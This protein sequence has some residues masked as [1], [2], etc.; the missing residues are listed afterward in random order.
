LGHADRPECAPAYLRDLVDRI[1]AIDPYHPVMLT[2]FNPDVFQMYAAIPDVYSTNNFPVSWHPVSIV[3]DWL[4]SARLSMRTGEPLWSCLQ[5]FGGSSDHPAMPTPA[6]I[7]CMTYLALNHGAT[8][9]Q[10]FRFE[11]EHLR[12]TAGSIQT[13]ELW[14][15]MV[16]LAGE[17]AVLAPAVLAG[18]HLED[19]PVC[20]D[21]AM[22]CAAFVLD[23]V[24]WLSAVNAS[25]TGRTVDFSVPVPQGR[26]EAPF[27]TAPTVTSTAAGFRDV[28][29]P[30]QAHVYRYPSPP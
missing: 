4:D 29:G 15:E 17:M 21:G 16:L 8:G 26:A 27:E 18:T 2:N 11:F 5:A 23:D 13:P 7:R 6:E 10:Y 28:F 22:D 24:T 1:H 30:W 14:N 9:I 25:E 12:G 3:A 19:P 20:A